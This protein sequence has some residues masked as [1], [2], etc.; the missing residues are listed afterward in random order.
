MDFLEE[1]IMK[2]PEASNY[3]N[4]KKYE[5]KIKELYKKYL[6]RLDVKQ[7]ELNH[8]TLQILYGKSLE[9]IEEQFKNSEEAKQLKYWHND[10]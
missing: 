3:V 5:A 9:W 10:E 2:Y 7:E 4:G 6:D 1:E 8:W